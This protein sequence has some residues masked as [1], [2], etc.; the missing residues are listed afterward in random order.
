MTAQDA[1]G[2]AADAQPR[3]GNAA[4]IDRIAHGS[5][6][7]ACAFGSHVAFG[8]ESAHQVVARRQQRPDG[9]LRHGFLHRL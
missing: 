4:R 7:R 1:D 5:V 9:A 6:G 3:P 8:G 2:I